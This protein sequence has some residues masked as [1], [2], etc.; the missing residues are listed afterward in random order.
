MVAQAISILKKGSHLEFSQGTF[1]EGNWWQHW[2]NPCFHHAQVKKVIDTIQPLIA[3]AQPEERQLYLELGD[4]LITSYKHDPLVQKM[5]RVFD[6]KIAPVRPV[7]QYLHSTNRQ[8]FEKWKKASQSEEIF[9]DYPRFAEFLESSLLL[10]QIKITRDSVQL[11]EGSPALLVDGQWVKEADFYRRFEVVYS[12]RWGQKFLVEKE[13]RAVYTYLDNGRGLEK[14]HPFLDARKSISHVND[15]EYLRTWNKACQFIR[16][17]EAQLTAQERMER[18]QERPFILQLVSEKLKGP[19]TNFHNLIINPRHTFIRLIAGQDN[20]ELGFRKGDVYEF[21]FYEKKHH[22]LPA[23]ATKGQFVSPDLW[24]Y[25]TPDERIVTNVPIRLEEAQKFTEFTMK[26]HLDGINLGNEPGFHITR[27]NCTVYF[28]EA[29]KAAGIAVPI[30]IDLASAINRVM[31]EVL[32]RVG[33]QIKAWAH[34]ASAWIHQF[35]E[36]FIHPQ[37]LKAMGDGIHW[38]VDAIRKTKNAF[39]AFILTPIRAALGGFAGDGGAAFVQKG[40]RPTQVEPPLNRFKNWFDLSTYTL[41]LPG[42]A[43]EWQLQQPST[44][45]YEDHTRLAIIARG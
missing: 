33:R 36:R 44:E 20:P 32:R 27:Q 7:L 29:C 25:K 18:N 1:V 23:V 31:P 17:E 16:P 42:I 15:E 41:N 2:F 43:Q 10:S 28:R 9:R 19:D 37:I 13:T 34:A 5:M 12:K 14:H 24:E 22:F 35:A 45:V 26:Y 6:R 39:V 30:Q 21:G 11:V 40:E 3:G 8:S 4:L 38:I